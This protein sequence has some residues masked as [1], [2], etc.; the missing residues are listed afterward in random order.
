MTVEREHGLAQLLERA[1]GWL[2]PGG[3]P[4]ERVFGFAWFAAHAGLAELP[5]AIAARVDAFLP[6]MREIDL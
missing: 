5:R 6:A 1:S 3:T 4:Q 2:R